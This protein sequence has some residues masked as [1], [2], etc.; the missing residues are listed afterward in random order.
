MLRAPTDPVDRQHE[1][2]EEGVRKEV[3]VLAKEKKE[4]K[5]CWS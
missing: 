2:T 4:K 3:E 5:E 1:T